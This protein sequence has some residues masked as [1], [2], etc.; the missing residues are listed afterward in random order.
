MIR[1]GA[2]GRLD[3]QLVDEAV[4]Q[5]AD[6]RALFETVLAAV[7][8]DVPASIPLAGGR[9]WV[10]GERRSTPLGERVVG[11]QRLRGT[12]VEARVFGVD[13]EAGQFLHLTTLEVW[14]DL[15]SGHPVVV[16]GEQAFSTG[17]ADPQHVDVLVEPLA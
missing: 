1:V 16:Y 5:S 8:S 12:Q 11:E 14:T 10:Q 2:D 17:E 13:P 7:R 6:D 4:P 9:G 3:A 15:A